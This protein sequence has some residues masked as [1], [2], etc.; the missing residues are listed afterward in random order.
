MQLP[1]KMPGAQTELTRRLEVS[2]RQ[3]FQ[4]HLVEQRHI[5]E[6]K[7]RMDELTKALVDADYH[8]DFVAEY[9]LPLPTAWS[10]LT[11]KSTT[12]RR[13]GEAVHVH[14]TPPER[15]APGRSSNIK[16]VEICLYPQTS[17]TCPCGLSGVKM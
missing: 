14:G 13:T 7:K 4:W 9:C 17:P 1:P 16:R 10:W 3:F 6:V 12:G 8:L 2:R 11:M 15:R 5:P